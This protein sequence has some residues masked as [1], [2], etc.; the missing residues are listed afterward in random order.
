MM[1]TESDDTGSPDCCQIPATAPP[2]APSSTSIAGNTAVK[3]QTR[4][5]RVRTRSLDDDDAKTVSKKPRGRRPKHAAVS[6]PNNDDAMPAPCLLHALKPHLPTIRQYLTNQPHAHDLYLLQLL[7]T[8]Q[9]RRVLLSTSSSSPM[10]YHSV[11]HHRWR[12]C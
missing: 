10:Q 8:D 2:T 4:S 7:I 6:V 12:R 1:S 5:S 11:W 3:A 9:R